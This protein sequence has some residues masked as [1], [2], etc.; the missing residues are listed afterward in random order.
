M[1]IF[2]RLFSKDS[3]E[4]VEV[5][6]TDSCSENQSLNDL[7]T[8]FPSLVESA[9]SGIYSLQH[10][11]V[12]GWHVNAVFNSK[13]GKTTWECDL[14]FDDGNDNFTENYST[15]IAGMP[16]AY[17]PGELANAIINEVRWS[18]N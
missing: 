5:N 9:A 6:D 2:N 16:G 12:D 4:N 15:G 18:Q 17:A 7:K 14:Y 3:N 8:M 13:S 1:S 10:V 11:S